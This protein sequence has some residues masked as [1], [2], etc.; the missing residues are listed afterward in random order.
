MG[1]IILLIMTISH[2]GAIFYYSVLSY[3]GQLA[4]NIAIEPFVYLYICILVCIYPF[5][6]YDDIR[7][8]DVRG[9]VSLLKRMSLFIIFITIEPFFENL[10]IILTQN[11]QYS[12]AYEALRDGD[13]SIMDYIGFSTIGKTLNGWSGMFKI[14]AVVLFFFY[15]SQRYKMM[16]IGL[17]IVVLH[18]FLMGVSTGQRGQFIIMG[19][20]CVLCFTLMI[21][22]YSKAMIKK[23]F[24]YFLFLSMPFIFLFAAITI[25]RYDAKGSQQQK[26]IMQWVLLYVSEGP[27]KFN[28][29]MYYEDHN[30][31]GDVNFCYIKSLLGLET[32][33]TY[34]ERDQ[35]YLA[36][37]GRRIEVF[38]TFVGD[39]VS[40]FGIVGAGLGC[41]VLSI[42]TFCLFR[43]KN[44]IIAIDKFMIILFLC[45]M[46]VIG[47]TAN[48]YRAYFMQKGVFIML[49][50]C[51]IMFYNRQCFLNKKQRGIDL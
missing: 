6:E 39:F 47:F 28:T 33:T 16:S 45:H 35:H 36:K 43:V 34:E 9:N 50:L 10:K 32:Y 23:V 8:I 11:A 12:D 49:F 17:G 27:I 4:G 20:L 44:G 38:Y 1:V 18:Y 22:T 42:I 15:L 5:L 2:I 31:N 40:D 51:L 25:S 48:V 13:I 29:Q 46:Y 30:T 41:L 14:P 37:N 26:S 3:F 21:N 7:K 19:L 24:R